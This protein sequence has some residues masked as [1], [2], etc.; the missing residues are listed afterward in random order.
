M[1]S[2]ELEKD[3]EGSDRN[4][5]AGGRHPGIFPKQLRQTTET[6]INYHDLATFEPGMAQI[7]SYG[8]STTSN[9]L[10]TVPQSYLRKGQEAKA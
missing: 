7:R 3:P 5:M 10:F 8:V 6:V 2:H 9:V 4:P 1:L